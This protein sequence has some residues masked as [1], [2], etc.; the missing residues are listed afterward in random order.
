MIYHGSRTT[1]LKCRSW[2]RTWAVPSWAVLSSQDEVPM[3]HLSW[4]HYGYRWP[5]RADGRQGWGLQKPGWSWKVQSWIHRWVWHGLTSCRTGRKNGGRTHEPAECLPQHHARENR[6][7]TNTFQLLQLGCRWIQAAV[8]LRF[9]KT[10]CLK[11]RIH[12]RSSFGSA[13]FWLLYIRELLRVIPL[14]P[15]HLV[16]EPPQFVGILCVYVCSDIFYSQNGLR[17]L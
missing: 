12:H 10:G 17:P 1:C 2:F 8:K 5:P 9:Q 3:F 14:D 13:P 7:R 4:H 16:G 11:G 6:R 15:K